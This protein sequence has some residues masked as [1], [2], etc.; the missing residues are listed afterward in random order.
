MRKTITPL[1]LF[2]FSL[3]SFSAQ[4]GI[5]KN[6]KT[7]SINAQLMS[8]D[9]EDMLMVMASGG[10]FTT[11]TLELQGV[12]LLIDAGTLTITGLG[13]N[14]NLYLPGNNPDFIPYIG[15]GGQILNIKDSDPTF[16]FSET[17][18]SLNAQVG[19]KQFLAEEIAINY[20]LQVISSDSYDATV[21]SVGLTIFLD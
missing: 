19:F 4:A 12:V 13:A 6:D 10:L 2:I 9:G 21:A 7:F 5:E 18:L 20:Q 16:G 3:I 15:A 8:S 14:A 17:E 1:F 11:E